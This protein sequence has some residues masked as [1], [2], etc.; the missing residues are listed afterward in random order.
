[1]PRSEGAAERAAERGIARRGDTAT[2]T[3]DFG[4]RSGTL[5][6]DYVLPS[7]DLPVLGGSVFWPRAGE[8]DAKIAAAS[9]HHLVWV[10]VAPR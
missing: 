4:P 10:D 6:L 8:P 2:H 7:R 5:R 1:V 3:G 9:D